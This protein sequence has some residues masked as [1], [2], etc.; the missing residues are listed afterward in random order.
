M[1]QLFCLN[2]LLSVTLLSAATADVKQPSDVSQDVQQNMPQN[3]LNAINALNG[4]SSMFEMNPFM[5]FMGPAPFFA[6][7]PFVL[8]I[9]SGMKTTFDVASCRLTVDLSSVDAESDITVDLVGR[10]VRITASHVTSSRTGPSHS[11]LR[12]DFVYQSQTTARDFV[13][14]VSQWC[15]KT[16]D[17]P[18]SFFLLFIF[19]HP[20]YSYSCVHWLYSRSSLCVGPPFMHRWSKINESWN[21]RN[22]QNTHCHISNSIEF[23]IKSRIKHRVKYWIKSGIKSRVQQFE[24]SFKWGW[25][26]QSNCS[27]SIM[28]WMRFVLLWD[29]F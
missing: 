11:N 29:G 15:K 9:E 8:P 25:F 5:P 24:W 22:F 23:G 1:L 14:L 17:S 26:C 13:Y 27:D 7:A 19:C 4:I 10:S 21:R 28:R 12:R 3:M 16:I 6:S 20:L 18:I 2:F